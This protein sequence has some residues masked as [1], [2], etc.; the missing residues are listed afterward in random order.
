MLK[1]AVIG[2]GGRGHISKM[3]HQPENGA[4]L[5]ALCD[6]DPKAFEIY[7]ELLGRDIATYGDYREV[8][9]RDDID[10]VI[11]ATPDFLHEEQAVAALE[12]GKGVYLE[13]PMAI[14]IEGCDRILKTAKKTG[15]KL[16]VGHNMRFFPVMQKMREII[17]SGRIGDVQ[18]IWCRHFIS[19]GGDAYFK[20]W[21]SES[22]NTT[23]LLLQKG[24]HDIDVI[25]YLAGSH[26]VRTVGMGMLSVYDKVAD[27]RGADEKGDARIDEGNWPPLEQKGV[28]PV[29]DVEDHSMVMMQMANGVQG[30]Y[31]QCH[32][33]PDDVRNYTVIGTKGRIE[34]IGDHS[35]EDKI[36][37]VRVWD[38]RNGFNE[39]GDEEIA[40]PVAEG[41]HGGA[42]PMI[43]DDF[44][45]YLKSG[46]LRGATP[47]D[48]RQSVAVGCLATESLR[49]GNVAMDVPGYEG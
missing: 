10:A 32:Y 35:T 31:M 38:A 7:H 39:L 46:E 34:N 8:L 17:E 12:A 28:S 27:R 40:V 25:H 48:A 14:T 47:W 24:A 29:I 20:D 3:A 37:K 36:A 16:Y 41:T 1:L 2:A 42:D 11:I 13:K 18:A 15:I 49:N 21:H 5:V 22:K 9:K 26:T 30:S 4:A 19:Y 44:V 45:R 33:S 23:G 43:M 6:T